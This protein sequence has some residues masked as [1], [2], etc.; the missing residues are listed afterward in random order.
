MDGDLRNRNSRV[1]L[2]PDKTCFCVIGDE[3]IYNPYIAIPSHLDCCPCGF[4]RYETDVSATSH[5]FVKH[6]SVV[7]VNKVRDRCQALVQ[8]GDLESPALRVAFTCVEM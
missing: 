1:L 4:V 3:C 5:I 7:V 2:R 6:D 8:L